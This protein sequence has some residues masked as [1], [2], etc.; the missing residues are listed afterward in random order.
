MEALANLGIDFKVLLAQVINFGILLF[1][2][3]KFLYQPIL[4]TLDKRRERIAQ[5]LD[6]A[7]E[8][9][10]TAKQAEQDYQTKIAEANKE[11]NAIIE[12]AKEA[13]DKIRRD[14]LKTATAEAAALKASAQ[15]QIGAERRTLY[16]DVK[17]NVGKLSLFV[18]TKVLQTDQGADF[19]KKNVEK[20]LKEIE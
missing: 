20:A 13:A 8:I 2:L 10:Q 16:A 12:E 4:S 18:L 6:K 9:D 11:A 3:T 14:T 19:Y 17:K 15:E 7:E 1:I 5:S